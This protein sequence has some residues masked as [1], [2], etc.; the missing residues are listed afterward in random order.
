MFTGDVEINYSPS[1]S[2]QG[3]VD[4][5][6]SLTNFGG[7]DI[8]PTAA[9]AGNATLITARSTAGYVQILRRKERELPQLTNSTS[10]IVLA[11]NIPNLSSPLVLTRQNI[12]DIFSGRVTNWNDASLT[13]RNPDLR[14]ALRTATTAQSSIQLVV[15]R[16]GS[17]TTYNFMTALKSFDPA[18]PSEISS[19]I[20]WRGMGNGTRDVYE[21]STNEALG[22][23]VSTVPYTLTYMDGHEARLANNITSGKIGI[24]SL[25][26]RNGDVAAPL[27]AA[28]EVCT[29]Y[30][31]SICWVL[32]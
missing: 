22:S 6:N 26:N 5:I 13:S 23:V 15:R 9:E 30:L 27:P 12:A 3:I 1:R 28:M 19:S 16:P 18:F 17:G 2:A 7:S 31:R 4:V 21:A 14:D 25:V 20:D 11:Y 29:Y 10:M 8:P 24:A 32:Y